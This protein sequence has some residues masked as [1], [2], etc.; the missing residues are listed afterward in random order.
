[1]ELIVAVDRGGG[2]G[3]EG[4]LL[5]HLPEDM[6]RFKR[7]TMGKTLLM[8]RETF[9]SLPGQR[10]LPG[11][12]NCVLSRHA[13]ALRARFP[14]GADGPFFYS[15]IDAFL[16]ARDADDVM[17]IGG[18]SVYRQCL[19]LCDRAHVTEIHAEAEADRHFRLDG[20]EWRC[21]RREPGVD[22]ADVR[23]DFCLYLRR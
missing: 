19:P 3:R 5:Y 17:V 15:S 18:E 2:I 13:E 16:A 20:G 12:A 4:R 9:L 14:A 6:K 8:G 11:R 1:M 10:P 22:A 23:Y 7:L 21:V